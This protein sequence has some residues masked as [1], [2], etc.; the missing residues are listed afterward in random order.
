MKF[1]WERRGRQVPEITVQHVL[2]ENVTHSTLERYGKMLNGQTLKSA[3]S[4][5]DQCHVI[6]FRPISVAARSWSYDNTN[7]HTLVLIVHNMHRAQRKRMFWMLFSHLSHSVWIHNHPF[8]KTCQL[9][10]LCL[11][12]FTYFRVLYNTQNTTVT[13]NCCQ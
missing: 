7:C 11:H 1:W 4:D 3:T 10:I 13:T 6:A 2:W 8:Q 12:G 5:Y 9:F